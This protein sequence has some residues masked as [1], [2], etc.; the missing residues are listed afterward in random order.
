MIILLVL[1]ACAPESSIA[2]PAVPPAPTI[3]ECPARSNVAPLALGAVWGAS[4]DTGKAVI[5]PLLQIQS[6]RVVV[7][8]GEVGGRV[9]IE[10]S[11]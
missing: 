4:L 1:L 8:C 5:A 3:L 7:F 11:E 9:T 2:S 10:W 6:D